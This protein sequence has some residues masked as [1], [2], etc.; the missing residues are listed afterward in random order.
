[1]KTIKNYLQQHADEILLDIKELVAA[2]SPSMNKAAVDRCG[3]VLQALF[4]KRLGVVA[5]IDEQPHYGNHLK[6][7]LGSGD[8]QTVL[9]GHFDTVWDEGELVMREEDIMAIVE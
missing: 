4:A 7:T 3:E 1:M 8:E 5:E 2:E 9:L 6:F